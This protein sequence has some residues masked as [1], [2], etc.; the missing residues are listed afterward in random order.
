VASGLTAYKQW[1]TCP[2]Q[3]SRDDPTRRTSLTDVDVHIYAWPSK[4]GVII[5]DHAEAVDLEFLGLDP[6][7]P[8]AKRLPN[9]S[10]EDAFCRRLL[11]LGAKWWDSEA[12]F[13][14]LQS[15]HELDG[16][17]IAALENETAPIPTMKE[18][19]WVS[20]AW[21]ITG[22]LWVAEFDTTLWGI[23]E[24]DNL[25]PCESARLRLART[26]DERCQ[27]LR[28]HFRPTFYKDVRE[29]KGHAFLNS[30]D[31]KETGEVGP[32]MPLRRIV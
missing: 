14:L 29:Y 16:R 10:D 5:H 30:W 7:N 15:A 13:R 25:L 20:V 28:D 1:P 21:P 18:R 24:E 32:L 19:R 22:G 27:V 3:P 17:A 8:P 6:L 23:E 26:M 12:R 4:G 9:Q 11:R 31:E 2:P